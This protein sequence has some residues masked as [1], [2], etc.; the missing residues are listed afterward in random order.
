MELVRLENVT[1]EYRTGD[2]V[3]HALNHV[4]LTI[5]KAEFTVLAGPSGSGKTT[6]LNMIGCMDKATKGNIF[7]TDKNVTDLSFKEASEFRREKIGFIFQHFYLIPVLTVYENI[8]FSLD[9]LNRYSRAEKKKKIEHILEEVEI[10]EL[11]QR[12]PHELSGGQQQRVSIA[13]AL[14]K[15]PAIILADEPTA[16][17]DSVTGN[18]ILKL[19]RKL[20]AEDEMTFIFSSHNQEIIDNAKRVVWLRDGKIEG[21]EEK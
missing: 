1:R 20:N 10:P 6:C 12:R 13:R 8:E 17:L 16:N 11:S 14:V 7:I 5:E 15:D 9:L 2:V 21:I 19:M 4:D 3:V 18:A